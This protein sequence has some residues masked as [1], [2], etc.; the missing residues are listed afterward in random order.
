MKSIGSPRHKVDVRGDILSTGMKWEA[1]AEKPGAVPGLA[2]LP[3]AS[4]PEQV[5][6]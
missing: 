6:A 5:R 2:R 1:G 4:C 3:P